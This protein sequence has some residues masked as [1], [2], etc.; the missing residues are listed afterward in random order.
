MYG[1]VKMVKVLSEKGVKMVPMEL[2]YSVTSVQFILNVTMDVDTLAHFDHWQRAHLDHVYEDQTAWP[3]ELRRA[4]LI[5]A[6]DYVQVRSKLSK[7]LV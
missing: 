7:S 2:K 3:I 6:V 1:H 5:P 4:R